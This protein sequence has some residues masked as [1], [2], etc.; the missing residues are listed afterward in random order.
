MPTYKN[1]ATLYPTMNYFLVFWNFQY[2]LYIES[3]GNWIRGCDKPSLH[4][5]DTHRYLDVMVRCTVMSLTF[6][7]GGLLAIQQGK[8]KSHGIIC[9]LIYQLP[10]RLIPYGGLFYTYKG[11]DMKNTI[12]KSLICSAPIAL[13]F[14]VM[15]ANDI[16]LQLEDYP[17]YMYYS[18]HDLYLICLFVLFGISCVFLSIPIAITLKSNSKN[19]GWIIFLA[20]MCFV[21]FGV[22]FYLT[23]LIWAI[24]ELSKTTAKKIKLTPFKS[25]I[26]NNTQY[27]SLEKNDRI[28]WLQ[29]QKEQL[30]T[31]LT[32]K[33]KEIEN[34]SNILTDIPTDIAKYIKPADTS[35]LKKEINI[36]ENKITAINELIET[37]N[38][39]PL[40][41]QTYKTSIWTDID[42]ED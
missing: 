7:V 4:G 30:I 3:G 25:E 12:I 23:S 6:V 21:P 20:M 27:I 32:N 13:L 14:A 9:K 34:K 42:D 35:A 8:P 11:T 37:E 16:A 24:F 39:K 26:V 5:A 22:V 1:S 33:H 18:I 2:I 40:K 19:K 28:K 29:K 10:D 38:T 36:L 17:R 15:N 31:D 41:K